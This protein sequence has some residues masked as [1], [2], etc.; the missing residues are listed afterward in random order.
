MEVAFV[1][2]L[3][4]AVKFWSVLEPLTKRLA[5]MPRPEMVVLPRLAA[6][7]KKFVVEAV[8][9]KKL[10]LVALLVVEF[11]T[12]TFPKFAFVANRFVEDAVVAKLLVV[13]A[14]VEVEL[15]AVKFWRVEEP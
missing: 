11:P 3:L 9:E 6:V 5:K 1:V 2:V 8:P 14:L 15:S 10:V 7:A 4:S 13:V 12:C